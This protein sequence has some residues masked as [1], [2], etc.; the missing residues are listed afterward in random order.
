MKW[1][2]I[3]SRLRLPLADWLM[4]APVS[5]GGLALQIELSHD[6]SV[7]HAGEMLGEVISGIRQKLEQL[8][9]GEGLPATMTHFCLDTDSH[10]GYGG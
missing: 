4:L 7:E 3:L 1:L 9:Q 10:L 5:G 6:R 2:A 8:R